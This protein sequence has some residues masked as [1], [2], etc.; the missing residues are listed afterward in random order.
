MLEWSALIFVSAAIGAACRRY[1]AGW[2]GLL[3]AVVLPAGVFLACLLVA[4]AVEP[5]ALWPVAF[6]FGGAAASAVGAASFVLAGIRRKRGKH[7]L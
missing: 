7:A 2:R 3:F 4:Q 6:V 1:I 5:I